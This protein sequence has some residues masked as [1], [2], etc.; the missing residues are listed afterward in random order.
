MDGRQ[1]YPDWPFGGVDVPT[2]CKEKS[3]TRQS[4]LESSDIN[5]IV[6]RYLVT[7]VLPLEAGDPLFADVSTVGSYQEVMQ[8]MKD[9]EAL[10]L[11][12]PPKVRERFGNDPAA[13]LDFMADLPKNRPEAEE[14]GLVEKATAPAVVET[15]PVEAK[16]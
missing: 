9:G 6:D 12:Q 10:L 5:N 7:G 3:M 16:P 2:V 8:R 4:E 13:F 11:S 15:P 14:L 1:L